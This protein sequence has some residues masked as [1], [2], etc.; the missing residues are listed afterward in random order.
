MDIDI[1]KIIVSDAFAY[2]KSEKKKKNRKKQQ[3]S[4]TS[5]DVKL[6]IKFDHCLLRFHK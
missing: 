6:I 4:N 2:G 1:K 5:Y 3:M